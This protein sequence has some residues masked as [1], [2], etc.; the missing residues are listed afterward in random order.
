MATNEQ[1][2]VASVDT[3][4]TRVILLSLLQEA[5]VGN[6]NNRKED[7]RKYCITQVYF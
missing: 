2:V 6:H 7:K 3:I 1:L 4:I 5:R